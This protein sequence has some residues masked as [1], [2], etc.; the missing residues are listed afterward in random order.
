KSVRVME[1]DNKLIF[2]V[3]LKSTKHDIKRAV[4][5]M[6]KVKVVNVNTAIMPSGEKK[7]YV[8]LSPDTPAI[9]VATKLGLI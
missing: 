2:I 3:E 6:F 7:A 4:E 5:E 1:A 9:D 8:T